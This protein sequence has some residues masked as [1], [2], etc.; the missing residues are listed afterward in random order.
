MTAYVIGAIQSVSNPAAF[1]EYQKLAF[2][3]VA[4]HGGKVIVGG[5]KIEVADGSWSPVGMVVLEFE[6][7]QKAKAWYNS[8]DYKP[9]V[10]RRTRSANSGVVFIDGG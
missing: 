10:A 4:K 9:L 8:S 3:T 2:P 6:N 7:L 1:A 5:T